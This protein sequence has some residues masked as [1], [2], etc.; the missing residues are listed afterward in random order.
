VRRTQL[1]T[2][3]LRSEFRV[4]HSPTYIFAIRAQRGLLIVLRSHFFPEENQCFNHFDSS[5]SQ[6]TRFLSSP[7]LFT[8]EWITLANMIAVASLKIYMCYGKVV[9]HVTPIW[10]EQQI[11]WHPAMF[12]LHRELNSLSEK[13]VVKWRSKETLQRIIHQISPM[14]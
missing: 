10:V 1:S 7:R 4:E 3:W 8:C 2:T 12:C 13:Q 6:C 11:M 5:R 9:D 14:E